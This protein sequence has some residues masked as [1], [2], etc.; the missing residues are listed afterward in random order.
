MLEVSA[1]S[2]AFGAHVAQQA[3]QVEQLYAQARHGP[4][5]YRSTI[6]SPEKPR[7]PPAPLSF[8]SSPRAGMLAP[9]PLT[10]PSAR[11][12][13]PHY[14]APA[15]A[16]GITSSQAV[17][18]SLHLGKGNAEL[19]KAIDRSGGARLFVAAILFLASLL[20]LLLDWQA[21]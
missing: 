12:S 1:L 3:A 15:A 11:L 2:S 5:R 13:P 17:E 21:G 16:A 18:A 6:S 19:V 14:P 7:P 4:E 9:P 10:P 8:P 20:L